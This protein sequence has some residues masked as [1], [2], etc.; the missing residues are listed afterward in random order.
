MQLVARLPGSDARIVSDTL[1]IELTCPGVPN[2]AAAE[3][4]Y[5]VASLQ[6]GG[7]VVA[8]QLALLIYILLTRSRKR[9]RP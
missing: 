5:D 1:S 9:R 4:L 7:L 8:A 3:E 6:L 2:A